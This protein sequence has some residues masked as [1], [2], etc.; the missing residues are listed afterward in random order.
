MN[1]R[2]SS[3]QNFSQNIYSFSDNIYI[4]K[5]ENEEAQ[6]DKQKYQSLVHKGVLDEKDEREH[7]NATR[8]R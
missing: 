3:F 6:A 4:N 2:T 1:K 5:Q 7:A 8:N